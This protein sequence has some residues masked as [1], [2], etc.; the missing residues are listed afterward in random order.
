MSGEEQQPYL[1]LFPLSPKVTV[2][3]AQTLETNTS[4]RVT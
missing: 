1:M 4:D 3:D 2:K